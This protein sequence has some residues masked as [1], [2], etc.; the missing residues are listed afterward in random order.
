MK[1]EKPKV[2]HELCGKSMLSYVIDNVRQAKI[3]EIAVVVGYG[4]MSQINQHLVGD[5][6]AFVQ[7]EQLGKVM[8]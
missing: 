2:L 5:I 7:H 4:L 8:R 1:S 6:A 3:D